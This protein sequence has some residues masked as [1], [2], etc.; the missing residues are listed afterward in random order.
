MVV[1]E[2]TGVRPQELDDLVELPESCY[3]AWKAFVELHD[4]RG[5]NGFGINP[6]SYTDI[7]AYC[8][9]TQNQLDPWE[10]DLVRA[11]DREA[12][13]AHHEQMKREQNKKPKSTH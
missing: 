5:S 12:M 8:T 10:V 4:A 3:G 7:L 6:I 11:F 13:K 9:L 2:R 1:W